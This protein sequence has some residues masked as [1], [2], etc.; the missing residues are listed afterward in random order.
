MSGRPMTTKQW[1]PVPNDKRQV[2]RGYAN[3]SKQP[4]GP[5]FGFGKFSPTELKVA[6]YQRFR[7]QFARACQATQ[8]FE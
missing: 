8:R 7:A 2:R 6:M 5:A 1:R 4:P 3:L